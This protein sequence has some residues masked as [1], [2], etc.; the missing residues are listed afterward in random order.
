MQVWQGSTKTKIHPLQLSRF[1][2]YNNQTFSTKT[3]QPKQEQSYFFARFE[4]QI[5]KKVEHFKERRVF[6]KVG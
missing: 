5:F 6:I 3:V 2:S 1:T 4:F